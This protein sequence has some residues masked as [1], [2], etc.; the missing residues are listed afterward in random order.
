MARKPPPPSYPLETGKVEREGGSTSAES[1]AAQVVGQHLPDP[2][3]IKTVDLD[4]YKVRLQQSR[5]STQVQIKLGDGGPEDQPSERVRAILTVPEGPHGNR[6][7]NYN[8]KD[9]AWAMRL[10]KHDRASSYHKAERVFA[11]VV[12]IIA[13]ERGPGATR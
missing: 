13:S 7:F 5:R 10:S 2:F 11:D 12:K 8:S 6:L 3:V 9:N 1:R 4:G